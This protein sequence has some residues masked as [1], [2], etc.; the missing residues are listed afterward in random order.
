MNGEDRLL[1]R[2]GQVEVPAES[3]VG[4]SAQSFWKRGTTAM[5]DIQILNLN[6]G[7]Y[8]CMTPE[9]AFAKAE[10]K[11]RTYTFRLAWSVNVLLL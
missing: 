11:I 2:P 8:L 1:E 6:A 3:K 10:K 7:S 4:I 5:F 9:K